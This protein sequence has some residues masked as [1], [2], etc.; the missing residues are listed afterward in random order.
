MNPIPCFTVVT[1]CFNAAP[2]LMETARSVLGQKAVAAGR[3]RL[4]Y[5]VV[6]GA[7]TDGTA[8]LLPELERLG[9]QVTS[10]RDRGMYDGLAKGLRRA[11]GDIVGW[12]NAGDVLHPGAF[13]ALAAAFSF[14]GVDWVTGTNQ[15]AIAEGPVVSVGVPWRYRRGAL[16]AG[17]HDG[18]RLPFV[19]QESTYWRRTLM[20]GLDWE[21]FTRHRLAGDGWLWARFA[22]RAE[23]TVLHAAVAEFRVHPGQLSGDRSGYLRELEAACPDARTWAGRLERLRAPFARLPWAL[24]QGMK[25][26]LDRTAVRYDLARS[27]WRRGSELG[28]SA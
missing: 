13:D 1:T 23:L 26:R 4:E 19:Q 11:S 27:R 14:P 2:R 5:L 25:A 22:E 20:D 24:G 28:P 10:G 15:V 17:L 3:A 6:D 16:R 12:L 9:A 8:N 18:R 7:S 21:A